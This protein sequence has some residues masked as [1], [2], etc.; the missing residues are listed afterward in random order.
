MSKP[1]D[2]K[3]YK[4]V[5]DPSALALAK[6][7]RHFY[8][9]KKEEDRQ[10]DCLVYYRKED[11]DKGLEPLFA[12]EVEMT[13]SID[14][15]KGEYPKNNLVIFERKRTHINSV[16]LPIHVQFNKD[17]TDCAI[18][19]YSYIIKNRYFENDFNNNK[20]DKEK[21]FNVD[22]NF[23]TFGPDKVEQLIFEFA[24]KLVINFDLLKKGLSNATEEE[25][26]YLF[27]QANHIHKVM[28]AVDKLK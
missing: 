25:I 16:Y 2:E 9:H 21:Y 17:F 7:F 5:D 23:I 22:I 8:V 15:I 6:C 13:K 24:C 19:P 28:F 18:V 26:R 10:I 27:M 14:W 12:I 20:G 4:E 3:L 1:F 11:I